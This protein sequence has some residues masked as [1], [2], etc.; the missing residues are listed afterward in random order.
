MRIGSGRIRSGRH[1]QRR[2]RGRHA[3]DRGCLPTLTTL[4]NAA[5]AVALASVIAGVTGVSFP[6]ATSNA[7][8]LHDDSPD[9]KLERTLEGTVEASVWSQPCPIDWRRST[10]HVKRLI[11]CAAEYFGVAPDQALYI[12]WRESRYQ[13]GAY[14]ASGEAAGVYQHLLK[15]WADRADRYGFP[16]ASPFD[17][18]ANIFVTMQMV[19]RFGWI[20]W[21]L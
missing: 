16:D 18:R 14:N 2:G 12:A 7:S 21:S 11:R 1:R 3:A 20:P 9:T 4:R 8:I 5:V 17:A 6:R 19:R 15:Y 13:P 10:W